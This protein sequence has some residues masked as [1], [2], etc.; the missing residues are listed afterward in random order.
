MN[1]VPCTLFGDIFYLVSLRGST[2]Y[3]AVSEEQISYHVKA[4]VMRERKEEKETKV[5]FNLLT[6][7]NCV[8]FCEIL[9]N[10]TLFW[11]SNCDINE[12]I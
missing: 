10:F 4:A 7:S 11:A 12:A 3:L 5:V 9:D 8:F 1:S 6:F 2:P